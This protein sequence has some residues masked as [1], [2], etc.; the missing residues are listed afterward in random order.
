MWICL[1]FALL[2]SQ[3]TQPA[4]QRV[5]RIVIEKSAH[6]MRLWADDKVVREYRPCDSTEAPVDTP[7]EI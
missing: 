4:K 3:A 2:A 5:T 7:V 1:L 6:K